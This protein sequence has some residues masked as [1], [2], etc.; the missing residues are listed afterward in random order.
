MKKSGAGEPLMQL[1]GL[2]PLSPRRAAEASPK[3]HPSS[4]IDRA[5]ANSIWNV[6]ALL[7]SLVLTFFTTPFI[8]K[9]LGADRYGLFMLLTAI[10]A[11]L[12][13]ANLSLGQ[14]TIK[15]IAEA[16]GRS[17]L[18][19][20]GTYVRITLLF[21]IGVGILGCLVI[22]LLAHFLVTAVFNISP[23]N[24]RLA[25][26]CLYW[27]AAGWIV[28]QISTTFNA[29]P[30]ALQ[31]YDLVAIGT[32]LFTLLNTG[33]GIAVLL[34]GGNLMAYV[35]AF[36][37]AQ[38]LGTIG[39]FCLARRLLPGIRLFPSWDG[40]AF[41]RSF[42][43]GYWQTV[44]QIGGMAANQA[45]K[46]VLGIFMPMSAMG[47]YNIA[48]KIEQSA[49]IIAYKM[50][51]VLFPAF[52][53]LQGE[54]NRRRESMAVMRSSWLVSLAAV[55]ILVPVIIWSEDFLRLW[56]GPFIAAE[57]YRTLQVIT[58]AG[59]LAS[60]TSASLFYLMGIG[61]TNWSAGISVM[62]GI[63]VLI[64]SLV[65]IPKVGL[66][67]AGWGNVLSML[68]RVFALFAIWR[69]FLRKE[70]TLPVYLSAIYGPTIIG[71]SVGFAFLVV[72]SY[73]HLALSW[74]GLV[75]GGGIS[76]I[77]L[78]LSIIAMDPFL[79]G[80]AI[81]HNDVSYILKRISTFFD[82]RRAN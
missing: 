56:L 11:P 41:R 81:R 67:G 12:G 16:H 71:L 76:A 39:W 43:F 18:R 73:L 24:Q 31:R 63:V 58:L 3:A 19:E 68:A 1:D 54:N 77:T 60:G 20:A 64:G 79:P 78:A 4:T 14:A 37:A 50:A 82:W 7:I 35:Q 40:R 21:N 10:L 72:K 13:L 70:M 46:Y 59:L 48:L 74:S 65:L 5:L 27:I 23:G 2:T 55:T 57:T 52:S 80:G 33:M 69:V 53:S 44:S 17:D 51:E 30:V 45:D 28:T 66:I 25:Q 47:F 38:V 34:I 42:R 49:F 15:F 26:I 36:F 22:S 6:G 75:I 9:I 61:K 62:T 8:L 29:V 32:I